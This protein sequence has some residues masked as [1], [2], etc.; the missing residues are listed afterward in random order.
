MNRISILACLLLGGLQALATSPFQK[1]LPQGLAPFERPVQIE[2]FRAAGT[3]PTGPVQSLG[4]W[5]EA[6]S[7]MTLWTNPSYVRALSQNGAITL[8]ADDSSA[9]SEWSRWL[10]KNQISEKNVDYLIAP[11]D[12]IWIRDYGPWWILDGKNQ[13]GIVDTTYNRPRPNDDQIPSYVAKRLQV[14]LFN[15]QL[16]HTGGNYYS[17]GFK[18]AFS[19][20]LVF[21]ENR[22][23]SVQDV[24]NRMLSFLGIERYTTASLGENITIEHMDTFGKLVSPDTWVFSDFPAG[25]KFKA[26]AD[27]MVATLSKMLSA[28]G[29]PYKIYRMP[30]VKRN[31]WGDED[32]RAYINSFISNGVL[33]F[34]VYGNDANDKRAT[35]IYQQA[36]PGYKIVGVE[37]GN[38]EWGD[39]VHCRSRNL[40]KKNTIFIFPKIENVNGHASIVAK[41]VPSPGAQLAQAPTVHLEINGQVQTATMDSKSTDLF[42]Y[43]FNVR[44]GDIVKFYVSAQDTNGVTKISPLKAPAQ[45]IEWS[46]Q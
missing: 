10:Q 27:R 44:S 23:L 28:Y 19:S 35:N 36:L 39:S 25:S 29:T 2:S 22:S 38:T 14:P 4:E 32:Y 6:E 43:N 24:L 21:K 9:Q 37:N 41:V 3:A 40:L 5:E 12:S 42:V 33:Y 1:N 17:D 11:T 15:P 31:N 18:S 30:M 34:P 13:F 7:V 46:V 16:I 20:T 26:D 8:I 45:M